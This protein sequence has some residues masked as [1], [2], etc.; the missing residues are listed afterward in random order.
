MG[1]GEKGAD[2]VGARRRARQYIHIL[3][4]ICATGENGRRVVFFSLFVRGIEKKNEGERDV[5]HARQVDPSSP[6]TSRFFFCY[7]GSTR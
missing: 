5:F 3:F 1:R 7:E 4:V 2:R 6:T